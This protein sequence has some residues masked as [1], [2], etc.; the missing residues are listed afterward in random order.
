[1][2]P[3]TFARGQHA[4]VEGRDE[5]DGVYFITEG[6][7]EIT[8]K[9]VKTVA[10][11][12]GLDILPTHNLRI[13]GNLQDKNPVVILGPGGMARQSRSQ[14]MLQ[15]LHVENV[16]PARRT[17]QKVVRLYIAGENELFGLEEIIED[18]ALRK[19]S[20]MC[21]STHASAYFISAENFID[22]VNQYKFS[23]QILYEQLLKHKLYADRIL[24]T[25]VFQEK[26][27]KRFERKTPGSKAPPTVSPEKDPYM[28]KVSSSDKKQNEAENLQEVGNF[29]DRSLSPKKKDTLVLKAFKSKMKESNIHP[30]TLGWDKKSVTSRVASTF[31]R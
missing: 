5:I 21:T 8:Q 24:Q 7:F 3:M 20:V 1:M 18:T 10:E 30:L 25:Q 9:R 12:K 6:E 11:K 15:K 31:A 13:L 29:N 19:V 28:I 26:F 4:F 14:A 27:L 16:L 23:D 2:R 22:C 17:T